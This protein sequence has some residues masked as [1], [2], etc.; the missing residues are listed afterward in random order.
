MKISVYIT[1]YNQKAFLKEAI[2]SVLAQ[3]LLPN[4]IVIIDDASTD[5]SQDLIQEYCLRETNII[6]HFNKENKGITK[7]RNLA[8][9]LVTGDL[10]TW[11]DGD[12]VYLP[13]KLKTQ[14]E[15]I[16]Q[17]NADLVYTNF[18]I[19]EDQIDSI[20]R[21]W[22]S[23]ISQLP[24]GNNILKEVL[25][26]NFPRNMLFRYEM[27]TRELLNSIGGYDEKIDIYEDFEYRIRLATKAKTAFSMKVLSIYRLH[28]KGLSNKEKSIHLSCLNYILEKH[29]EL[30]LNFSPNEQEQINGRIGKYLSNFKDEKISENITLKL[31]IKRRLKRLIDK[32]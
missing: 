20:K 13:D 29:K 2:D 24:Q 12:D 14:F 9:S 23:D 8:L 15:L 10:I 16:Q 25:S 5:G 30:I 3:T 19:S 31:K 18:Y 7:N 22:C 28:G 6:S 32:I 27:I 17:T 11:L 26:R 1:S 21:V 4:E